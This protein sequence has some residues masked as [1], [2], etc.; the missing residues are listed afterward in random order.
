[1]AKIYPPKVPRFK[2]KSLYQKYLRATG[3][4]RYRSFSRRDRIRSA[5][6]DPH[7]GFKVVGFENFDLVA[8]HAR[9]SRFS[10]SR[11][12]AAPLEAL[13]YGGEGGPDCPAVDPS[14]RGTTRKNTT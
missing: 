11:G 6:I 7:Y 14:V 9:K 4:A 12:P 5:A 10:A 3:H 1:M 13:S 2:H 8:I